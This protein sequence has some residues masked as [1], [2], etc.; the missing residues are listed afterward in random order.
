[1]P[2]SV[3]FGRS[4][5]FVCGLICCSV[6]LCF[7][8]P[9]RAD[10][11]V[12][13]S[14]DA[15]GNPNVAGYK[16]Y[17]GVESGDYTNCLDVGNM[18]T[19][20][21]SG[22]VP[23]ATYYFAA[24]TYDTFGNESDYSNEATYTMPAAA[25]PPPAPSLAATSTTVTNPATLTSMGQSGGHFN[26]TVSGA[27]G[28]IYILLASSDLVNWVSVQTNVA[29]FVF[30]EINIGLPQQFYRA[31]GAMVTAPVAATLNS[32]VPSGSQFVF[33][34]PGTHGFTYVVEASTDLVNWIPVQTNTAPFTFVDPNANLSQRFYRAVGEAV[35]TVPLDGLR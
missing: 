11:S 2:F 17:Y 22:L 3:F 25:S 8:L 14:W 7:Q 21:V 20:K 30:V 18:T 5:P 16:I 34:I 31:V 33:D 24:T 26:F 23:A 19:A 12:T 27:T 28:S 1:M 4:R 13:L 9:V 29:P 6:W 35:A 32:T 15:A 10:Q